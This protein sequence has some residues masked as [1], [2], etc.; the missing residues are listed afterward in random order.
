MEAT[1][2]NSDHVNTIGDW[3][4]TLLVASIPV[5]NLI[6]LFVWAFG[7]NNNKNRANW[8]KAM[9]LWMAIGLVITI[10]VFV[11]FGAAFM[12]LMES[13]PDYVD[14]PGF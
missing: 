7:R 1:E 8:A 10:I 11:V 3:M 13:G 5:V 12:G 4:I 6:M 2:N 14:N 9:L